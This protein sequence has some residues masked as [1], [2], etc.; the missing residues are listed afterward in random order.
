MIVLLNFNLVGQ[1]INQFFE[2]W[3]RGNVIGWF[4]YTKAKTSKLLKV[5]SENYLT[6]PNPLFGQEFSQQYVACTHLYTC[7]VEEGRCGA[8]S[9]TYIHVRK[10]MKKYTIRSALKNTVTNFGSSE[11]LKENY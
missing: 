8:K 1:I 3:Q 11:Y 4:A 2:I 10:N 7:M 9:N 5:T 6:T